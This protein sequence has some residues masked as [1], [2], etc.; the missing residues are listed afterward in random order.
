MLQMSEEVLD[1]LDLNEVQ[2]NR[3]GSTETDPSCEELQEGSVSPDMINN[4]FN[5]WR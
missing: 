4:M 2:H 1:E 5:Q 3:T